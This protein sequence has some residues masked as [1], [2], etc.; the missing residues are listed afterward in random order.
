MSLQACAETVKQGD[1]DRF[2]A[3]MASPISAR[4]VLFPIYAFNVEVA[5]APWVTQETMIAEMRL[6]WWRDALDEI[7]L[8][9]MVRRHEV[10]TPMSGLIDTEGAEILD[11]LV[12]ARRWDV[13][14]DP[15]TDVAH[16][17]A[18]LDATAGGLLWASSRALG[19]R[20]CEEQARNIGW[21]SGLT[22]WFLAVPHLKA[23]GR[24]PLVDDRPE[25]IAELARNGLAKLKQSKAVCGVM[26]PAMLSAWRAQALLKMVFRN[27]GIVVN[28]E[29]AQSE[30]VRRG[31]LLWQRFALVR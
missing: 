31:S 13:Y 18:Y 6:Q 4:K 29:L 27:P 20:D 11:K 5:R 8:G 23:M 22:N 15:F 19:A 9:G 1:P 30:F 7:R 2:L 12:Q 16:F 10:I 17:N 14:K 25:A 28:G 21:A 24:V 26:R 3:T